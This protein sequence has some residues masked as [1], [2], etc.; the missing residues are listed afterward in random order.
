MGRYARVG[1]Y[2]PAAERFQRKV[3][4]GPVPE[5]C[6]DLGPCLLW[7]GALSDTGY[8]SIKGDDRK[9]VAAHRFAWEQEHGPIPADLE[10]DHLC[11]VRSCVRVAH[12]ELVTHRINMARG[13]SPSAVRHREGVCS[14]G[15]ALRGPEA[16]VYVTRQG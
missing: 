3:A 2:A 5:H 14:R 16:D 13:M 6:P 12:M 4:D 9:T 7:T 8:G 1:R 15:H 11:R 10:P